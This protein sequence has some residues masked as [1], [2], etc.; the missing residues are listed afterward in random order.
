[1]DPQLSAHRAVDLHPLDREREHES[2]VGLKC[3]RRDRLKRAV[4]QP[5]HD[6]AGRAEG[7]PRQRFGVGQRQPLHR[8]V[9]VT[10]VQAEPIERLVQRHRRSGARYVDGAPVDRRGGRTFGAD[11]SGG[12]RERELVPGRLALRLDR[13]VGPQLGPQL[14]PG[15]HCRVDRRTEGHTFEDVG[16]G[17]VDDHLDLRRGGQDHPPVDL[18]VGILEAGLIQPMA[19]SGEWLTGDIERPAGASCNQTFEVHAHA[20]R[21]QFAECMQH[22]LHVVTAALQ[23]RE[24]TALALRP[25]TLAKAD[26]GGARS[27]LEQYVDALV[28]QPAHRVVEL[29]GLAQVACPVSC[30]R[31]VVARLATGECRDDLGRRPRVGDAFGR[32]AKRLDDLFGRG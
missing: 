26:Q 29:N 32:L 24:P 15:A 21:E 22:V 30:G 14:D 3:D 13:G 28:L 17:A 31:D 18:V 9:A 20:R 25:T 11:A 12:A 16:A 7:Q 4:D 2:L 8:S 19:V 10:E 6:V 27:D 23:R 1:M 5:G